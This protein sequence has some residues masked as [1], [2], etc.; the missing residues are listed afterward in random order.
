MTYIPNP[1][2]VRTAVLGLKVERATAALPA[3]TLGNIFT[4]SG[5]RVLLTM[6]VG[7]VTT[8]LGAGANTITIGTAPTVGTGSATA[9]GGSATI[10]TAAVGSHFAATF[11]SGS[12]VVVDTSTQSGVLI[13]TA[14]ILVDAGSVTI[15]TTATVTG[16]VKWTLTY[17]PVDD[18][19]TVAAA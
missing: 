12:A 10:T 8:V 5:G 3:G 13:P 19:A 1:L 4:V 14:G 6:L 15:T 16:S 18:V 2:G 7:E 17:I 9:L 11:A